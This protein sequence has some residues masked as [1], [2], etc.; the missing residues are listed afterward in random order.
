MATHKSAAGLRVNAAF[1]INLPDYGVS[2]PRYM[3]VGVK[4]TV[5]VQ[6]T[7]TVTQ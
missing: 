4:N 5:Q 7:F 3:G 1:P 2:E 6:V